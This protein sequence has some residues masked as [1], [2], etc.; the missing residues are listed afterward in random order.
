MK[1][2]IALCTYN[3]ERFLDEQLASIAGQT[4]PP[5][6][7]VISDDCSTDN[8]WSILERFEKAAAFPVRIVRNQT[9]RG[10]IANFQQTIALCSH[11]MTALADQDD[12]WLPDKLKN[13]ER[14]LLSV[15]NPQETLYCT[16][17]QYV[18]STL[19]MLG[20]S[21]IPADTNF[22]N[23]VVENSATGCSVVF[24]NEIKHIFLRAKSTD[25]VMH[26]WW[27]YL[28]A[29]AFGTVIYDAYPSL[30]YRQ[31]LSNVTGWQPRSKKLW[32]RYTSLRQRLNAGTT[33]MDS[34]NQAAR[35]IDTYKD[36]A[37][38]KAE[39]VRHLIKLR[40]QNIMKRFFYALNPGVKRNHFA[41][42]VGLRIM[43][44]MGWH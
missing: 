1:I 19:A 4:R 42:N 12:I 16:R 9:N 40:D 30:L 25:M 11:E 34:L 26:D 38:A 32:R 44:L 18:D 37:P 17:L 27:L 22:S 8:T 6:E 13:A 10:V 20:L 28:V 14:I 36:L 41:E 2:S 33:G 29:T 31:H 21:S 43:I 3:G 5:D 24:G 15:K 7:V 23:A 39:L 35:F